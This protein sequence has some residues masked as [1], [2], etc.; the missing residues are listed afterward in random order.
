MTSP[1]PGP[2]SLSVDDE[3]EILKSALTE[4]LGGRCA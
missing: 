4:A 1:Q 2:R 3:P